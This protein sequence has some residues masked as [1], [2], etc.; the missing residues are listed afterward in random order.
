MWILRGGQSR[1]IDLVIHDKHFSPLVFEQDGVLYLPAESVYAVF[2]VKQDLTKDHMEYAATFA[3]SVRVLTR[4]TASIVHAGGV[5]QKPKDPP[6]ILAGVLT[7]RAG[8][9]PALG[10]SFR[11][12]LEL[13]GNRRLDLGC[14]ASSG[15]W[16]I[17]AG[18]RN[19]VRTVGEEQSLV[20]FVLRL[21]ARLQAMGTVS[22]M[23]YEI[24]GAS[25][26]PK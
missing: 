12:H 8:W 1:A 26:D 20:F 13:N 5:I 16:E 9:T 21:L 3:E 2:E 14:V 19:E 24:W 4:T 7:S 6:E 10:E 17:Q 23:D 25:L 15:A 11:E 22:A 18:G